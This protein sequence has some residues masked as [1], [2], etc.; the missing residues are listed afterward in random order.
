MERS[1]ADTHSA[2]KKLTAMRLDLT[3][4]FRK[5]MYP[6]AQLPGVELEK[7]GAATSSQPSRV[8]FTSVIFASSPVES[9]I[10]FTSS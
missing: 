9:S 4:H 3:A 8:Y 5:I 10:T 7:N 1:L 2:P 6:D